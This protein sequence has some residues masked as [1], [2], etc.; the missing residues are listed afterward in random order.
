MRLDG[1]GLTAITPLQQ[2]AGDFGP[3]YSPD[4]S[5]I[6]FESYDREGILGAVYVMNAD[7]SDIRRITPL[8]SEQ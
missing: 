7:G 5:E 6:A 8:S 2:A 1:T 3:V 4:G